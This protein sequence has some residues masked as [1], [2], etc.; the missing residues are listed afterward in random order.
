MLR[1]ASQL[2]ILVA[3]VLMGTGSLSAQGYGSYE[4]RGAGAAGNR[5][6]WNAG[7]NNALLSPETALNFITIRAR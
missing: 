6:P 5:P 1:H 2:T 3:G 7:E 4:S